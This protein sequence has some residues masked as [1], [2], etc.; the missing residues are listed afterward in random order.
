MMK[1]FFGMCVLSLFYS[2][3]AAAE[4]TQVITPEQL[5]SAERTA[6]TDSGRVFVIGVF[7]DDA[8]SLHGVLAEIVRSDRGHELRSYVRGNLEGTVD[9]RVGGAPAG[10][11]C[12]FSGMTRFR[13]V[14]YAACYSTDGRTSLIAVD[15]EKDTVRAGYFTSCNDEPSVLPCTQTLNVYPNGMSVD[16]EGR[17]YYTNMF[18]HLNVAE[19]QLNIDTSGTGTLH[20]VTVEDARESGPTLTFK[21]RPWFGAGILRD[22]YVPNGVQ[23]E[24]SSLFYAAGPNINRIEIEQDGRAGAVRTYYVGAPLS[25]ID[26]FAVKDGELLISQLLL[27]QAVVRATPG[28]NG[29]LALPSG[30]EPLELMTAPSSVTN[31]PEGNT[32]FPQGGALVTSWVGGGVYL[33]KGL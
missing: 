19:G 5:A 17:I 32:V 7:P 3:N 2:A 31:V 23:I 4:F 11:A 1:R 24:G 27:T 29:V 28:P 21:R 18:A 16:A 20:Q 6:I 13:N 9:G 30:S 26:D 12:G 10:D 14:V 15:T 25:Y 33:L 8:D 22:S